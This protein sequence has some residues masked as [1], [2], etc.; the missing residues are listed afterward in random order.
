[1]FATPFLMA[2]ELLMR[3][4]SRWREVAMYDTDKLKKLI[5]T[6]EQ[7]S[8]PACREAL[9]FFLASGAVLLLKLLVMPPCF[10]NVF[11]HIWVTFAF[12]IGLS[13]LLR[14]GDT[15]RVVIVSRALWVT[16]AI[17]LALMGYFHIE[18]AAVLVFSIGW[19]I[20]WCVQ[21]RHS[22]VGR[23]A[24]GVLGGLLFC[25]IGLM[26]FLGQ[27]AGAWEIHQLRSLNGAE[28]AKIELQ[29]VDDGRI[30]T[31]DSDD[32]IDRFAAALAKTYVYMPNHEGVSDRDPWQVT[33]Q[34]RDR[35]ARALSFQV[36]NGNSSNPDAAW[37]DLGTNASY[38]SLTL[39]EYLNRELSPGLWSQVTAEESPDI[40]GSGIES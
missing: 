10:G 30:R 4:S 19:L 33:I 34:L 13:L 12:F 14:L 23:Q 18:G 2:Q 24:V 22:F 7:G 26:L 8:K 40:T 39:S 20:G 32:Q 6:N 25:C 21:E 17:F 31:I 38:Q 11:M 37:I 5:D 16:A 1:M 36:G 29:H 28:I 35:R 3:L 9:Y 27:L 15:R